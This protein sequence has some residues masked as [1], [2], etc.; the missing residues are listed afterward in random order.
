MSSAAVSLLADARRAR[1]EADA[2]ELAAFAAEVERVHRE[3]GEAA[4]R[5]RGV[6][7]VVARLERSHAALSRM[8]VRASE[9][10]RDDHPEL[11]ATIDAVVSMDVADRAE[12][13]AERKGLWP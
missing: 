2:L 8:L 4:P 10:V 3:R 11:A 5:M 6:V 1:A 9:A 13:F 7:R 12:L